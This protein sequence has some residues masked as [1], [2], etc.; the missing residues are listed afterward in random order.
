MKYRYYSHYTYIYPTT[1]LRNCV[2]EMDDYGHITAVFPFEKEIERTEFYSGLLA[3]VPEGMDVGES[4]WD[5]IEKCELS[6]ADVEINTDNKYQFIHIED[7]T[8]R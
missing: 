1:L 7:F 2:V 4:V 8:S 6:D 5:R 3:F